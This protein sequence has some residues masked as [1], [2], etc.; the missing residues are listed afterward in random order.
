[1]TNFQLTRVSASLKEQCRLAYEKLPK[2]SDTRRAIDKSVQYITSAFSKLDLTNKN[3][4]A[5]SVK[6]L[7]TIKIDSL[8]KELEQCF[9]E[10]WHEYVVV[11]K[12]FSE[13]CKN[14][15]K[16][17]LQWN[18]YTFE[19]YFYYVDTPSD[20]LLDMYV[21]RI[22]DVITFLNAFLP[23]NLKYLNKTTPI[24][25]LFTSSNPPRAVI[26]GASVTD[27]KSGKCF[28]VPSGAKSDKHGIIVSRINGLLFLLTHELIHLLCQVSVGAD[29][30]SF[31]EHLAVLL[32]TVLTHHRYF[33]K[34]ETLSDMIR[35]EVTHSLLL[36]YK[37]QHSVVGLPDC[38]GRHTKKDTT[39]C[40]YVQGR[41]LLLLSLHAVKP[42]DVVKHYLDVTNALKGVMYGSKY[43]ETNP[44]KLLEAE[45]VYHNALSVLEHDVH[46][47][48]KE[49]P[50]NSYVEDTTCGDIVVEYAVHD[51]TVQR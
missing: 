11:P 22:T 26:R 27:I 24:R 49:L 23:L 12:G 18:K 43:S 16:F 9:G 7:G 25:I 42:L 20:K 34:S 46:K 8:S 13:E 30:E 6:S 39:L 21:Q 51:I 31:T 38:G 40:H 14:Y 3:H 47:Y 45:V 44:K 41:A 35:V 1:M 33:R 48:W 5:V 29:H 50:L 37:L 4:S 36:W 15:K 10:Y 28:F 32:H 17:C 2:D 19:V